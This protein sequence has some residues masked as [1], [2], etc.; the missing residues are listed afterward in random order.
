MPV[1]HAISCLFT[2]SRTNVAILR[3]IFLVKDT[4][5]CVIQGLG[6]LNHLSYSPHIGALISSNVD[7]WIW[8]R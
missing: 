3:F 5:T 1:T 2:Y 4:W 6:S 7:G 8:D